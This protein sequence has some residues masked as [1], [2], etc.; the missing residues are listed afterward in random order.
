V[1]TRFS[2]SSSI[3]RGVTD[4]PFPSRPKLRSTRTH[5]RIRFCTVPR[6]G[7][8]RFFSSSRASA[9]G[10]SNTSA[11]SPSASSASASAKS[12]SSSP[13]ASA[14]CSSAASSSA[15][16]AGVKSARAADNVLPVV[17]VVFL[18]AVGGGVGAGRNDLGWSLGLFRLFRAAKD[19]G[20]FVFRRLEIK[21]LCRT[22]EVVIPVCD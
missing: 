1:G 12:S 6:S 13:A 15:S 16:A 9:L 8:P 2:L 20:S 19:D 17:V 10:S 3:S 7:P 4:L 11:P 14:A 5:A 18:V 22:C 21:L